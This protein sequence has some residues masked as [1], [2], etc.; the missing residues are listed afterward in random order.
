M[1]SAERSSG[2]AELD[3]Q[4]GQLQQPVQRSSGMKPAAQPLPMPAGMTSSP[5]V[6]LPPAL[7]P[8]IW[9]GRS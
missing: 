4:T 7:S 8:L 1:P 5:S 3:R 6:P 9:E 2:E